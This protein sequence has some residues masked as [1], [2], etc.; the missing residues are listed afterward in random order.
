MNYQRM[1]ERILVTFF[2]A[3]LAYLVV[4]QTNL[5][6]SM[7]VTGVGVLGAGLS[8]VYNLLRESTPT[9]PVEPPVVV[10][11]SV[12]PLPP[13]FVSTPPVQTEETIVTPTK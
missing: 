10:Q 1:A 13:G 2:E 4:N 5:S 7:K 11:P 9:T 8:A 12:P 6:G 3:G